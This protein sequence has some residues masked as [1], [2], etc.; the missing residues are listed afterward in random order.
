M[1]N[2]Q[3]AF[4]KYIGDIK[5][6]VGYE[7]IS[8]HLIFD[9]KMLENYRRKI[10]YVADRHKVETPA[11]VTYS[12]VVSRDSV[13]ILLMIAA[14]NDLDVQG[15]DAQNAFL[16][17]DNLEKHWLCAGPEFGE[18]EGSI[19][20]V[21]KALY[22]LKSASASFRSFMAKRFDKLG[23]KSSHADPDV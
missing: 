23:F 4:E 3:V 16:T 21:R 7:E 6:L 1:T 18:E 8:A 14:L 20:I 17:A 5:D 2:N 9:V 19:F 22:G 13:R 11:S 10:R 12:T 15:C